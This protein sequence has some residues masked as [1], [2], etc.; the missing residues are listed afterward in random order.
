MAIAGILLAAGSAT[1]MGRN[2]LLLELDGEP[3]VRRAARRALEAGLDPLLV[4]VGHEAAAVRAALSGL[5]CRFVDNP[6][7]RRGQ[8]SSI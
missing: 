3:L 4:V 1:R 2:K 6:E 5:G 7:W 8:T